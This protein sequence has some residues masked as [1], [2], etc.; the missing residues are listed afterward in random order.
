[1]LCMFTNVLCLLHPIRTIDINDAS[2]ECLSDN[3]VADN[4]YDGQYFIFFK[5][6]I[7]NIN[8]LLLSIILKLL[9]EHLNVQQEN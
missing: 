4:R 7:Y 3:S 1:M 2:V 8:Y 9:S 6:L 5:Y